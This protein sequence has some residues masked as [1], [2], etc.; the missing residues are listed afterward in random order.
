MRRRGEK[1]GFGPKPEKKLLNWDKREPVQ[2][3]GH[4][5]KEYSN[6]GFIGTAKMGR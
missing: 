5:L 3:W 4:F 1:N 2:D 6:A